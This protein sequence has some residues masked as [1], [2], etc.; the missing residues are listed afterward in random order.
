ML[1][2]CISAFIDGISGIFDDYL[3][4]LV[5]KET[6]LDNLADLGAIIS[7]IFSSQGKCGLCKLFILI[8]D[9]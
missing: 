1:M 2:T 7:S 5:V 3:K 9:R 4:P 8:I 6:N